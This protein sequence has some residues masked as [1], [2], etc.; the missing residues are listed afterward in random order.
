MILYG[1]CDN[2]NKVREIESREP[3]GAVHYC[4]CRM[5]LNT[6]KWNDARY[7]DE[8]PKVAAFDEPPI[9]DSSEMSLIAPFS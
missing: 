9:E 5:G 7:F 8:D 1:V 2:C 6:C 4:N 3:C